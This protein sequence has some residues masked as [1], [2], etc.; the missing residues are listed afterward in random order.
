MMNLKSALLGAI[1]CLAILAATGLLT[2]ES[3]QSEPVQG[4]GTERRVISPENYPYFGYPYSPGILV[5]D[6]LYIAGHLGR[7]PVNIDLVD[8]GLEAET[9]Q[10]MANIHEVLK[11]ADMDFEDVVSV[12]AYLA[13][14]EDFPQ[15]NIVYREF[16]PGNPPARATVQAGALNVGA[17]VEL[18]MIAV[19]R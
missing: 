9:R 19:K 7:D 17:L 15:F 14:I 16:F 13:H 8:G 2:T 1:T 12:T 3:A 18:Q 10:A 5:G 11:E 6:T 4:A